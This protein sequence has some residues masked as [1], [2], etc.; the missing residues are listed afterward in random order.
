M[1]ENKLEDMLKSA[2]YPAC[3]GLSY[4]TYWDRWECWNNLKPKKWPLH[5]RY[6][7]PKWVTWSNKGAKL[8]LPKL[9]KGKWS[10]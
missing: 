5:L 1:V 9:L 8:K 3:V 10:I 2:R 4:S 7:P 6:L